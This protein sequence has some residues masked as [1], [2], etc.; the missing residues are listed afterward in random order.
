M[1]EIPKPD[2]EFFFVFKDNMVFHVEIFNSEVFMNSRHIRATFLDK[3][4]IP[5]VD[6]ESYRTR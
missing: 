4:E 1:F 2:N 3:L 5:G 6:K